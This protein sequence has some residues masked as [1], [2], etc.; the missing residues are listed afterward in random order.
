MDE[1]GGSEKIG[2]GRVGIKAAGAPGIL[3]LLRRKLLWRASSSLSYSS[4]EMICLLRPLF[5]GFS[6]SLSDLESRVDDFGGPSGYADREEEDVDGGGDILR[7]CV[8]G[9][10][11]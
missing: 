1:K 9:E 10:R 6:W 5:S 4:S 3:W 2:D 11:L 8:I 7:P